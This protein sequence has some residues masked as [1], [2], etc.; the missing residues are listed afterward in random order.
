MMN[1]INEITLL[2]NCQAPVQYCTKLLFSALLK[3]STVLLV[4]FI[5]VFI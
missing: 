4:L 2:F 5:Y 3:R 1:E